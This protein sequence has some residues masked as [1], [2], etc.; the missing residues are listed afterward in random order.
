MSRLNKNANSTS[1]YRRTPN[2]KC[3]IC[4][5]PLYRRPYELRRVRHVACM[6]HRAEAQKVSGITEAQKIGLS[7]GRVKGTNHLAGRKDSIS[8][9]RRRA[10]SVRAYWKA[11][12]DLA[13]ARAAGI[14][15]PNHYNWKGGLSRLNCSIR[16]MTEHRKWMD[17]VKARDGACDCGSMVKLEAHHVVPLADLIARNGVKNRDDA[18][19]CADLWDLKNGVTKCEKCHYKIHGRR[20]DYRREHI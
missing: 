12:P 3:L 15:G 17:A 5:K 1:G 19:A 18:R 2:C 11:H 10:K 9:R 7:L 14:R 4:A 6:K 8:T 20:Y 16:R 13:I